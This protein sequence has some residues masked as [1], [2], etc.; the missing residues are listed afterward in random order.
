MTSAPIGFLIALAGV[1]VLSLVFWAIFEGAAIDAAPRPAT[2]V[3]AASP[4]PIVVVREGG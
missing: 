4:V 3:V 2:G 1:F